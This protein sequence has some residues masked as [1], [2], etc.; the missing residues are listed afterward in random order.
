MAN[1]NTPEAGTLII[2]GLLLLAIVFA[3]YWIST[4]AESSGRPW[5]L[6]PWFA[7]GAAAIIVL[8]IGMYLRR[9]RG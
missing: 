8:G 2:A 6:L 5:G 9:G 1:G 3:G 7:G 4:Y